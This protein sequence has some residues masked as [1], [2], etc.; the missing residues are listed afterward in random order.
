MEL[1]PE[2]RHFVFEVAGA[3]KLDFKPGQFVS[4]T[5]VLH[6]KKVTRAYSIASPPDGNRFE[7]C[8]NRVQEGMFSPWLF[9]MKP[10]DEVE[11]KGPLGYFV[12]R[13]PGRDVIFVAT[14]TGIAPFRS[15]LKAHVGRPPAQQ[16]T[17]L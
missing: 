3:E 15:M 4:F 12:V 11:M 5:E 14:G 10:G 1:C 2:I 13:N 6:D 16:Y 17:L 7:L 9:A 8:L